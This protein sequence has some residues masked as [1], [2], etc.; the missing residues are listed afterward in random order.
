MD[1]SAGTPD[2]IWQDYFKK[3]KPK[4]SAVRGI[5]LKLHNAK[6]HDH[7][8]AC[9]GAALVNNQAQPW[10]YEVLALS[11]EI[12][13]YPKEDV[14]RAIY[15]AV[16]LS[17]LNFQNV[18]MSAAYLTRFDRQ[19]AALHMYR[20]A[21]RVAKTRP[22][23]YVM[24]LKLARRLNDYDAIQWGIS[25][26]LM[27]AWTKD[28]NALHKQAEDMALVAEEELRKAG[29]RDEADAMR[30]ALVQAKQRDLTLR[31]TW[32][33]V[34]DLDLLVEEP[35]GSVCSFE[36]PQ[37]IGGGA[38][39]HD[40]YGPEQENCYEQYV[41]AFG[42]PGTYRVRIRHMFGE[43]VGKRA[44]LTIVRY[45][46]TERETKREL[47]VKL[48]EDDQVIRLSLEHGRR[49][50]LADVS[51]A[52]RIRSTAPRRRSL[53]QM[54]GRLDA[55]SRRAA[56]EFGTSRENVGYQ[57]LIT[58]LSEGVTLSALAVVSGDRRYVRLTTVPNFSNITDVF[59]FSFTG[60]G[61][62]GG[63]GG[64]GIGGG[65]VQGGGGIG[66]GGVQGGGVGGGAFQGGVQGGGL[67]AF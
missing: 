34:G 49:E 45:Q 66:G 65:G 29:R 22:E 15:S 3:R 44:K 16:D 17:G 59:T 35:P 37:T 53:L 4:P 33:G 41:C 2:E 21:S 5:V 55:E 67:G 42:M 47:T 43:V 20:Q 46:G 52:S 30:T 57:P 38:L 19:E 24:G 36:N 14:E 39:V 12:A 60:G 11:M 6:Q 56:Q 18:M 64:G 23:P 48:A 40:G 31:L 13:G 62:G 9:I 54:V 63:A 58:T 51:P 7:V 25:G 28:H 61:G 26:V 8:I 32:N 1:L 50:E 27:Y 10:M